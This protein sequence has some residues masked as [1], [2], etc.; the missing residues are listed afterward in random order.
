MK[1]KKIINQIFEISLLSWISIGAWFSVTYLILA[2]GF[3]LWLPFSSDTGQKT[4]NSFSLL[5]VMVP[6]AMGLTGW[7]LYNF[8]MNEK[9]KMAEENIHEILSQIADVLVDEYV[10]IVNFNKKVLDSKH[11][12][13]QGCPNLVPPNFN[14][15]LF[16]VIK[17]EKFLDTTNSS[18]KKRIAKLLIAS[19]DLDSAYKEVREAYLR[20]RSELRQPLMKTIESVVSEETLFKTGVMMPQPIEFES[21]RHLVNVC[22]EVRSKTFAAFTIISEAIKSAG[23]DSTT[24]D[25]SKSGFVR[26]METQE[27]IFRIVQKTDCS[28]PLEN[29]FLSLAM[30]VNWEIEEVRVQKIASIVKIGS[31]TNEKDEAKLKISQGIFTQRGK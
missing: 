22:S 13:E 29:A 10:N 17:S 5:G 30:D 12:I 25:R 6:G 28:D 18:F 20:L 24:D 31:I 1:I 26:A 8:R 9:R 16:S 15:S 4:A 27:K 7:A 3:D 23:R 2:I 21:I 19:E 11:L 14:S